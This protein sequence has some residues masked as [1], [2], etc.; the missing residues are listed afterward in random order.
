MGQLPFCSDDLCHD[1]FLSWLIIKNDVANVSNIKDIKWY[2]EFKEFK[3]SGE[4]SMWIFIKLS[5]NIHFCNSTL[6]WI[7][8]VLMC[9]HAFSNVSS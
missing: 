9:L 1:P 5:H 2:D 3:C 4:I 6:I 7:S 8:M